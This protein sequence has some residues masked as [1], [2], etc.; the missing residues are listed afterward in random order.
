MESEILSCEHAGMGLRGHQRGVSLDQMAELEDRRADLQ[1]EL[2]RLIRRHHVPG[3]V[4]A[5]AVGDDAMEVASGLANVA[6][7]VDATTDTVFQIGS[8][9]KIFTATLIAQL[10]DAGLVALDDPVRALL[11]EFRVADDAA[12]LSI[13]ARNLLSHTSGIEGDHFLDCGKNPDALWRY[14]ST[15]E[16]V[17][18]VHPTDD[19]YSY[20]N[21]GYGVLGRLVEEITGDHFARA[22][23]K[24]LL[25][26]LGLDE[27]MVL[28]EHAIVHRVA[29]GHH[30]SPGEPATVRGWTLGRF[31][32]PMG[33]ILATAPDLVQFARLHLRHGKSAG[34]KQLLSARVIDDLQNPQVEQYDGAER[35]LGWCIEQW[36]DTRVVGHDGDTV[37]QRAFLRLF[38]D[39]D[40]VIVVLTNSP[41]GDLVARP[42]IASLSA[43]LLDLSPPADPV[44][45]PEMSYDTTRYTGI[46]QRMHQRLAV[47][48]SDDG[49]LEMTIIPD[50]LFRTAGLVEQTLVLE[51]VDS[52][53][54]VTTAP[55]TGLP[56]LAAFVDPDE[57]DDDHT[58]PPYLMY[59]GRAHHRIS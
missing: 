2:D 50:E 39:Q 6:T 40:A 32:V 21:S 3:A 53:R 4:V 9:S 44:A 20:C 14:V 17:G 7:G 56:T 51:A 46:Y 18:L 35:G 1:A 45:D 24:R 15:L 42:I 43:S 31:N 52:D 19:L 27:T 10:V 25:K 57:N 58:V 49:A 38:P 36:G 48:G 33:G 34:G 23:H 13:T 11:H 47:A 28:A 55:A 54:F 30:Q 5:V 29:A 16:E 26:P 37:G 12:T 41:L 8:I 22:L 59:G